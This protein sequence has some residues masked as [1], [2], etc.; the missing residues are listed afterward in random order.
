MNIEEKLLNKLNKLYKL[1]QQGADN[2][3]DVALN[4]L[5]AILKSNNL[6]LKDILQSE[7]RSQEKFTYKGKYDKKILLQC[8]YKV[9]GNSD[10]WKDV[11]LY[12][13][14]RSKTQI[15]VECTKYE[16]IEILLEYEFYSKYLEEQLNTFVNS[17]IQANDLFPKDGDVQEVDISQIDE[18]T[19]NMFRLAGLIKT[20]TRYIGIEERK[21]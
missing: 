2:E 9:L 5:N 15:I 12:K 11:Q 10:R 7:Q 3:K 1:S 21:N 4:K 19:L 8:I 16:K 6:D 20:K 14:Y 17:F 18:E 13:P